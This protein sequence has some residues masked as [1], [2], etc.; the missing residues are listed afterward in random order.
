MEHRGEILKK[1]LV[2]TGVS[3]RELARRMKVHHNTIANNIERSDVKDETMLEIGKHLRIDF[4]ERLPSLQKAQKTSFESVAASVLTLP[5]PASEAVPTTL[6]AC[7]LA[8]LT[9]QTKY[10]H[11]LET[12]QQTLTQLRQ[13]A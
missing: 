12:H 2:E 7:Q 5:Q 10:I 13:V 8:L 11:L 4:T 1:A 3:Q 6:P 9:L